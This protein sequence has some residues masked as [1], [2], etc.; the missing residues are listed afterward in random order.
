MSSFLKL[1]FFLLPQLEKFLESSLSELQQTNWH[2]SIRC[3]RNGIHTSWPFNNNQLIDTVS[4]YMAF[5]TRRNNYFN[6]ANINI[7]TF[8]SSLKIQ[9]NNLHLKESVSESNRPAITAKFVHLTTWTHFSFMFS[10]IGYW[11]IWKWRIIRVPAK[12][13]TSV[14]HWSNR[15]AVA[16]NTFTV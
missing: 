1:C 6:K 11:W 7:W 5:W 15:P 3:K 12:N 4:T 2:N 9:E 14:L 8:T 10:F 16:L 13:H